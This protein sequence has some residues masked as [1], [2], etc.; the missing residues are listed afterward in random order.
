MKYVIKVSMWGSFP[1]SPDHDYYVCVDENEQIGDAILNMLHKA[2]C[3]R[4]DTFNETKPFIYKLHK[5]K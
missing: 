1:G 4:F 2:K 5:V 3:P